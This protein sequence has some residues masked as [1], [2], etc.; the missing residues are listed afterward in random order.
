[1]SD[2]QVTEIEIDEIETDYDKSE[3]IDDL[4]EAEYDLVFLPDGSIL[5]S[6]SVLDDPDLP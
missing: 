5:E 1:M 4:F 3:E 2:D 6:V